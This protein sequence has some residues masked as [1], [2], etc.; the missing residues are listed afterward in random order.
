[1]SAV[2]VVIQ[3]FNA[4]QH[5]AEALASVRAQTMSDLEVILVDD[6]STDGTVREARRFAAS[7]DLTIIQQANSGPSAAR[8]AGVRRARSRYCA[9]L[10]ADDLM[11][12]ELLA[13]QTA[14]F[15]TD[16]EFGLVITDVTTF[17]DRGVVHEARWKFSEPQIGTALDRLL[18]ENF[19]TTSA[20]M[21]RTERLLE[22]GLFNEERRVAEDY[23]LWLRMA[24]RWKVGIVDRPLVRYR[25][26]PGS[27]SHDKVYSARSALGVIERFWQE[28]SAYLE[29]H[30]Q[31]HRHSLARHL[32]NA[33]AA[34]SA[35]GM[36]YAALAY[37]LKSLRFDPGAQVAWKWL[38]KTLL[39]PPRRLRRQSSS[40]K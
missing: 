34:A 5:I 30:P 8:N 9:F 10:D 17:D 35:E 1:M 19:V 32:A 3:A 18:L 26:R 11:L 15:E 16:P 21:A 22:A 24:A 38:A 12:P 25:Y 23:E 4:E 14:V 39:L 37:L 20:V 29:R 31:I 27:L 13:A 33:G 2:S 36:R 7:L 28:Q 6:G 40:R